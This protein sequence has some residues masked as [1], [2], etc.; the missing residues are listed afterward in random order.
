MLIRP[1][2]FWELFSNKG[3]SCS[4]IQLET[5]IFVRS[6]IKSD[7]KGKESGTCA[8]PPED[9]YRLKVFGPTNLLNLSP[10]P[11]FNIL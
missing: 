5:G 3:V 11:T 2:Y 7:F 1:L 4:R 10:F 9:R 8:I 6:F